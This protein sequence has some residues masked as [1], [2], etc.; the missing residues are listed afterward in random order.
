MSGVSI[1]G[2]QTKEINDIHQLM[3]NFGVSKRTISRILRDE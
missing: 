3:K 1:V 2:K